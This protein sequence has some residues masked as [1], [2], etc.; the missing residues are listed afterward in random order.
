MTWEVCSLPR[1]RCIPRL[2]KLR[3][4]LFHLLIRGVSLFALR[5]Y[6]IDEKRRCGQVSLGACSGQFGCLLQVVAYLL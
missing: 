1:L 5:S 6:I 4:S 3:S 2:A